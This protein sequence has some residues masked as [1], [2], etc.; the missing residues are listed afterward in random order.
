VEG[1]GGSLAGILG[2][3]N[4]E[5][6]L[7][8]TGGDLSALLVDLSGLE[9]GN[10][11]F[12]ALGLP[13]KTEV[14]CLVADFALRQGIM[15]TRTLLLDTG[16]ANITGKG[17]INLR[18]ETI[19]YQLKAEAKHFSIG[20]LPA[21]IDI[22]G[23]L[24]NPNIAPDAKDLAV[25]GGIAAGLGALLSPLAAL[26]PTIQLGLGKDNNCDALIRSAQRTP[27]PAE[28]RGEAP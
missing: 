2:E 12:S 27:N 7:F 4:G 21:P 16:E 3:G 1:T 13:K 18:V 20:S 25:R 17:S 15:N 8:M 26:L 14:R 6:K 10:A 23:R 11:L 28:K 22:T 9:F 24:K 19:D 5:L